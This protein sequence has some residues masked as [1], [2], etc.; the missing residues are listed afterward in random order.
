MYRNRVHDLASFMTALSVILYGHACQLSSQSE[1]KQD[2]Q[3]HVADRKSV[4]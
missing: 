3:Q 1:Q 2:L 4:V